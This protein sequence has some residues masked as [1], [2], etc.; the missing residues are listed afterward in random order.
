MRSLFHLKTDA[1]T[2]DALAG[3]CIERDLPF[4]L[5]DGDDGAILADVITPKAFA[6]KF[7]VLWASEI[8]GLGCVRW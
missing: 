6:P 7:R 2:A 3:W 8:I 1:S 5:H 4:S